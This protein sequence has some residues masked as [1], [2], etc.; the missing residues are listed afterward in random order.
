MFLNWYS[1]SK[2]CVTFNKVFLKL[3]T[4]NQKRF[5]LILKFSCQSW[6]AAWLYLKDNHQ[7]FLRPGRFQCFRGFQSTDFFLTVLL[8]R[9]PSISVI[10][11][12]RL[13]LYLMKQF[14]ISFWTAKAEF[15][16]FCTDANKIAT[17]FFYVKRETAIQP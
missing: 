10:S 12:W 15:H 6:G 17:S 8:Q 4:K 16:R 14:I 1:F 3:L 7:S 2:S 13:L 5:L 9:P 11:R